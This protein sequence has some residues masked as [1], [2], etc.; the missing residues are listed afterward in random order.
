MLLLSYLAVA[1]I[2]IP[3]VAAA[4][5]GIQPVVV[6]VVVEAVVRIGGKALKHGVLYGFAA[7]AFIAIFFLKIP[8][9]YIV[10]AAAC[11]AHL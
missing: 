10:V 9:P 11:N 3:A 4:F 7:A 5:Y 2:G 6:A 8:F 1:H